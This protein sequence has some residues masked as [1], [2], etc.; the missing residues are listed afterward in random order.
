M[1]LIEVMW[2]FVVGKWHKINCSGF[3]TEGS[4]MGGATIEGGV[5]AVL[6]NSLVGALFGLIFGVMLSHTARFLSMTFNR[7]L[8]GHS[9]VIV[10]VVI[11]GVSFAVLALTSDGK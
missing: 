4:G 11:G 10:G 2:K 7:N 9:W 1:A 3:V 8:G 6:L 5:G